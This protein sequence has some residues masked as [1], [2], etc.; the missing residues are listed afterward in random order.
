MLLFFAFVHDLNRVQKNKHI[1][2]KIVFW[3]FFLLSGL[4]HG[5]GGDTY[6]YRVFGDLLPEFPN[7]TWDDLTQYRYEIGWVLLCLI[8]KIVFGSFVFLQLIISWLLNRGIL[9]I[10]EKYSEYPFLT[11]LLFF[12]SGEQYFYMEFEFC[13]QAVS[14]GLFLIWGGEFLNKRQYGKYTL[15]IIVCTMFHFAS[16]C[17][18]VL[19]F[20]W[21]LDYSRRTIVKILLGVLIIV[22]PTLKVFLNLEFVKF[23]I[24]L[25]RVA[26]NMETISSGDINLL[27]AARVTFFYIV[28]YFVIL[29]GIIVYKLKIR[30]PGALFFGV[31]ICIIAPFFFD[32]IRLMFYVV[33]FIDIALAQV[34]IRFSQKDF[35]LWA[36][37]ILSY[38]IVS[39]VLFIWRYTQPQYMFYMYPYYSWFEEEPDSHKKELRGRKFDGITIPY[40]IYKIQN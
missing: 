26:N 24:A 37:G 13:R 9:K 35:R 7:V 16:F 20:L 19:P 21:N 31:V 11:L 28:Y 6:Q 22:I 34:I 2:L 38:L 10:V 40:Q 39:N 23:S 29:F 17:L 30:F 25:N 33:I 3:I 15:I 14:V 36:L 27:E 1:H 18:L 5:I 32:T 8:V 4:R 12:I